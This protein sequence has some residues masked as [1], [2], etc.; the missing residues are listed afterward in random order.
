LWSRFFPSSLAKVCASD[1]IGNLTSKTD[2][3][4]RTSRVF[5]LYHAV[6]RLTQ[7]TCPDSIFPN[8]TFTN[9]YSYHAASNRTGF[10]APDGSTNS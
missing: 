8:Q 4:G 3:K 5:T 2:R 7:K 9:A 10:T 1:A 6:N